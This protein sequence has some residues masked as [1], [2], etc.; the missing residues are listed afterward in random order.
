VPIVNVYDNFGGLVR[1]FLAYD[2]KFQGGVRVATADM[3]GDG[4]S[5]TITAP[6]PNGGPDV[7]V[8]DGATGAMIREFNAYDPAFQG[9]VFV[10]AGDVNHDGT[11]DIVTGAGAGGGPHVKVFDGV[12]GLVRLSFMAYDPAFRG[13]VSVAAG[14]TTGDGN[15]DII[16]GAGSGGGP[17]VRVFEGVTGAAVRSFFPYDLAFRG[18]VNVAALP[19]IFGASGIVTAPGAGGGPDIR[20]FGP[21]GLN[22][23]TRFL[24]YD[25]KFTGGVTLGV[26]QIGPNGSFAILTGAGPGGGPH[27][28]AFVPTNNGPPTLLQ[29][30][31]A[32]DPGFTGG[33]FVG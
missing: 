1:S 27:V 9:G 17:H 6:G 7:R 18:G 21:T 30:F 14:D 26:A 25:P 13:G 2:S 31:L 33:V 15:A 22:E 11:P 29:S 4:V 3:N 24:A 5:D 19:G 32:F 10:A 20:V 23:F 16:T 12:T 28:K 8:W